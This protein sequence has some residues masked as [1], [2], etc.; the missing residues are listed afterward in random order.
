VF[1]DCEIRSKRDGYLTAASTPEGRDYGYVFVN[2]R[3]TADPGV[4]K[5]YL[6]RPWRPYAQ[7][8]FIQ[9]ELGDHIRP[10]GW[11]NWGK[12]SNEKTAFYAEHRSTG[13]G[14]DLSGRVPWAKKL[15]KKKLAAYTIEKV[16]A[17][18]DGWNP[19]Q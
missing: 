18:D 7:T 10:E 12:V 1:K 2:C 17:G 15:K 6:G 19:L 8:V 14:A 3:L 13:P 16:L 4:E 9:C 11:H 5:V